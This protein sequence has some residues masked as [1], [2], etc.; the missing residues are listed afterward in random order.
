MLIG[1]FGSKVGEKSRVA[2]PKRFRSVLGDRLIVTY[3]FENSLI[4]VSQENW[5]ALLSGT[6]DKPF[7][8]SGARET[9]RFLLGGAALVELDSQGRFVLPDYLREFAGIDDEVVCIGLYRYV[10]MWDKKK[11]E[12]YRKTM[13]KNISEVAEKLVDKMS[14]R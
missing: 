7:L 14:Q 10:E 12:E 3:G 8:L 11:W 4:V 9:Q 5:K 2:F 13:Q 6:E 1:Q